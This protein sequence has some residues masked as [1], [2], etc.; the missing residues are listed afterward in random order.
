MNAC[1]G[2]KHRAVTSSLLAIGVVVPAL[3]GYLFAVALKAAPTPT[4]SIDGGFYQQKNLVSDQPGVALITDSNLVNAWGIAL[5]PTGGAF[6]VANN[7]SGTSTLY[8]GDVHGSLFT[9]SSLVVTIQSGL[10][11]GMVFNSSSDFVVHSGAASGPS[12]FL[13]A[14]Q[15]GVISGWNPGVPPP[16]PSHTAQIG[17]TAD[18]VYTGLAIAQANGANYLYA[19]DFEHGRIDVYDKNLQAAHLDGSFSDPNTPNSYSPFNVQAI[20]GRIY[21]TYA[22]QSHAEPDEETDRGS[23]FVDVFDTSGHLLQR[24]IKGNHLN[25]PWGLALAPNNF[26][27]FSNALIVGNFGNGHLQAFDP[28]NGR[29]LG[30]LDDA[31]GR[32]IVIDGLWGLSFGNGV[33]AGDTN[34]LYFAAGPDGETHGLFGSLR[35][36][37]DTNARKTP[38]AD[39]SHER[40]HTN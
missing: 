2:L 25:A 34:A 29:F 12:L 19:A 27:P 15:V 21:V 36:V 5:P 37:A 17:P 40:V 30:E 10:P 7:R 24:L 3:L 4:T 39:S 32:P 9:K 11:T 20:A 1:S 33:T 14:S 13:W 28:D 35:F 18:A 38:A 8:A 23:G 26:G 31:S 16:P 6:W 22:Q